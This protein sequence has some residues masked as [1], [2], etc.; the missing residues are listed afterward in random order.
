MR[1]TSGMRSAARRRVAGSEG[2]APDRAARAT[3]SR[4]ARRHSPS[5]SATALASRV[6]GSNISCMVAA[7]ASSGEAAPDARANNF[8]SIDSA[9]SALSADAA[10][11]PSPPPSLA[12][13]GVRC[14]KTCASRKAA[15]DWA[16]VARAGAPSAARNAAPRCATASPRD[17][18]PAAAGARS[19]ASARSATKERAAG[20]PGEG[21]TMASK[22]A[23]SD[24]GVS[25]R[26]KTPAGMKYSPRPTT[27]ANCAP[28][29][30]R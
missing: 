3:P 20:P 30:C 10:S 1:P 4:A 22:R 18:T 15:P 25:A 21:A 8:R 5:R 14:T 11:S 2:A 13:N 28:P 9:A 16:W 19:T 7:S 17:R 29:S 12:G 24:N 26:S 27:T 23:R 6:P